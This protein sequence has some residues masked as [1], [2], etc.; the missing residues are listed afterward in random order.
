MRVKPLLRLA[1]LQPPADG[2]QRRGEKEWVGRDDRG[3]RG[4]FII[5]ELYEDESA[6]MWR[7][8]VIGRKD[9][10]SARWHI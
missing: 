2:E 3:D 8:P 9:R 5:Q 4:G 1:A 10:R 6:A 7:G